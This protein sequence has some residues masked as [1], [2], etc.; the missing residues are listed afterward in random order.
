MAENKV[1]NQWVLNIAKY[2]QSM[3]I[4]MDDIDDEYQDLFILCR[5]LMGT[6]WMN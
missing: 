3:E 4:R 1:L 5:S 6:V 2:S